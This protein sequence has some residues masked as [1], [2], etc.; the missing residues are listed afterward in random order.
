M[1]IPEFLA[2]LLNNEEYHKWQQT[3]PSFYLANVLGMSENPEEWQIG[4]YST[5][6]GKMVM[7]RIFSGNIQNTCPQKSNTYYNVT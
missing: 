3:N 2:Y 1:E 7:F 6:K 5:E 4:F